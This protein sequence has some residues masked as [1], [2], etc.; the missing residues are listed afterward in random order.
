MVPPGTYGVDEHHTDHGDD[1]R[2]DDS[3]YAKHHETIPEEPIEGLVIL[4]R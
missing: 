4:S 3:G 2:Y 1:Q